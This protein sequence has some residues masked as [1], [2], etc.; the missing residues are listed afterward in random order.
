MGEVLNTDDNDM[1]E[2]LFNIIKN[3]RDSGREFLVAG[4]I[5]NLWTL[6]SLMDDDDYTSR[7][8]STDV[9]Q[10]IVSWLPRSDSFDSSNV[11]QT[12]KLT[13]NNQC[14]EKMSSTTMY[15]HVYG[16]SVLKYPFDKTWRFQ[17]K[18]CE[19]ETVDI[20]FGIADAAH[21]DQ[22]AQFDTIAYGYGFRVPQK[23]MLQAT[24]VI[25][26]E[27][28]SPKDE[29]RGTQLK[30]SFYKERQMVQ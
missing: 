25:V 10:C 21:I 7:Y 30:I 28:R 27:L 4:Y 9:I 2:S 22:N 6:N 8:P 1:S 20:V 13:N 5:R 24:D 23:W 11:D 14:V 16:T 17:I 3:H 18:S 15:S 12:I 19:R 26:V 29:A